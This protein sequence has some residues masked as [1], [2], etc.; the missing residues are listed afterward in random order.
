MNTLAPSILFGSSSFLQEARTFIK[1][2][3]SSNFNQIR[4][5]TTELPALARLEKSMYNAVKAW[6]SSNFNQIRPLT[7]E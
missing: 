2:W 6:M 1:A 3:M 4:P 5:L 7:M